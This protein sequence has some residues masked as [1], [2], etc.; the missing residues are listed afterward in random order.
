MNG[1]LLTFLVILGILVIGGIL[2]YLFSFLQ[3][4]MAVNTGIKISL[5]RLLRLRRQGVP[6]NRILENLVKA[7][8][9]NLDVGWEQLQNHHEAGGDL[10]N[11]IDGMVKGRQYGLD[12]PFERAASADLQKI[13]IPKAVMIIAE[14]RGLEPRPVQAASQPF[15]V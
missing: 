2:N 11:V 3:W 13:D 7:K 10:Y 6:A 4:Y 14:H 8:H 12:I 1:S 5:G 9:F 15:I